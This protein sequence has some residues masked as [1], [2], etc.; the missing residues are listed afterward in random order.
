[1]EFIISFFFF[2]L[3]SERLLKKYYWSGDV[4]KFC[5]NLTA[6]RDAQIS[7]KTFLGMSG[8]VFPGEIS[9]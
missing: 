5:V 2:F 3:T 6:L 8:R 4:K 9:L 1:M 7:G